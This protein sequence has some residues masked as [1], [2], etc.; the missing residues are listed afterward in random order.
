MEVS[1]KGN[2]SWDKEGMASEEES[3]K[4]LEILTR[5][6]LAGDEDIGTVANGKTKSMG[7]RLL[8]RLLA[9]RPSRTW[10]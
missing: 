10:N 9:G 1:R 2:V 7:L 8:E 5:D 4:Y 6:G 3:W